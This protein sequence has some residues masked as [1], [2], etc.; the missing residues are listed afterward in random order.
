METNAYQARLLTPFG[1]LGIA[2]GDNILNS[3]N[4]IELSCG[5]QKAEGA[6]AKEVCKQ[7]ETYFLDPDFQFSIPFEL[8][9]TPFQQ[10]VWRELQNI[11]RGETVTY[12]ELAARL[13]S[14][15]RA[16]GQACGANPIPIIVPCHRVVSKAG[17]GGF[18]HHQS[19]Y[20]ID[21][22][23]WL[24]EHEIASSNQLF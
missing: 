2:C 10:K 13:K 12:G 6:F 20:T 3:L 5:V 4:F 8:H 16:V 17:L 11:P 23:R 21:I 24:L 7:L 1:L 9:G 22:K 18:A 19:G 14:A 15:P